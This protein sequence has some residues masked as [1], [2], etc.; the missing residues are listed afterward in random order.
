[1]STSE[2]IPQEKYGNDYLSWKNWGTN[3]TFGKLDKTYEAYCHAEIKR[4]GLKNITNVLEIGFG[5]GGFLAFCKKNN[6]QVTGTE[7]NQELVNVAKA[8]GFEAFHTS[9]VDKIKAGTYDLVVAFDVLEH[10]E[11]KDLPGFLRMIRSWLKK[12]GRFL[13]RFPNGDS[14]FGLALQHGDITHVTT[15]GRG[16][17]EYFA[18][19]TDFEC[20]FI[21]GAAQPIFC[22]SL[23]GSLRRLIIVP[24]KAFFEFFFR[25]VFF[26]KSKINFISPNL[27]IIL[28]KNK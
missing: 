5:D 11:Q 1:M 8:S 25:V 3:Q 24:L 27:L 12:D 21:G 9:E 20:Q 14:P 26:A 22:G 7:E 17:V 6:W 10:I 19:I 2:L 16:K 28:K 18:N 4:T 13:A 15:L 23:L